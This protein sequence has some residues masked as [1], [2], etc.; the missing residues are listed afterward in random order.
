MEIRNF[1]YFVTPFHD[2][3]EEL[4]KKELR[5]MELRLDDLE[6]K[7]DVINTKVT[8]VVDAI[9]GNPLTKVGGLMQDI[10]NMKEK[11][12]KVEKKQMEYDDF[13]K[14]VYWTIGIIVGFVMVFQYIASIYSS[15]K[16]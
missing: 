8:Q 5:N 9:L 4:I 14:R 3:E 10:E 6:H 15:I 7:I 2:M 12:E 11:L 16:P 13:K 1:F